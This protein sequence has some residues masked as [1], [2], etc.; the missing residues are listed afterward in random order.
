MKIELSFVLAFH[1]SEGK[2]NRLNMCELHAHFKAF[3]GKEKINPSTK[4]EGVYDFG[5]SV[6]CLQNLMPQMQNP[7]HC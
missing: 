4:D 3:D 1:D 5:C 6:F 7:L 2:D